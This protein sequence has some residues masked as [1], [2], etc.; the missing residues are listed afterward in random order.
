M[1][2]VEYLKAACNA[3]AWR[4]LVWRLSLFTVSRFPKDSI[5]KDYDLN[6]REGKVW[7]YLGDEW[8]TISGVTDDDGLFVPEEPLKLEKDDYP[9]LAQPI[10][11]TV[12]KYFYNW[13]VI[14]YPFGTKFPYQQSNDHPRKFSKGLAPL[15]KDPDPKLP[16][17]ITIDGT[18]MGRFVQACAELDSMSLGIVPT[19][20]LRSLETHPDMYKLR[21]A[22]LIKYKDRLDD[23]A[24]IV[25]IQDELDKLDAEWLA[26]DQSIDFFQGSKARMRRRKLFLVHGIEGSFREDGKFDFIPTSLIEGGDLTQLVAKFNSVREGSYDRGAE[27]AKGGEQ[28]RIIQSIYQN[29]KVVAGDCG[30]KVSQT[31]T[32][33]GF[34]KNTLVGFNYITDKGLVSL[35]QEIVN[36]LEGKTIKLRRP[37]LCKMDHVDT[38]AACSSQEKATQPRTVATDISG[39]ASNSMYAA[40]GA[41]HG[42]DTV[43][44]EFIP[45]FHIT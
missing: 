24:T 19:G 32:V 18:M 41:M 13:L 44:S 3:Q 30:T 39:G 7:Y 16:D 21:D 1:N 31:I 17:E 26:G 15:F 38:C 22:L 5:P 20:T 27:T 43:V 12:G 40:M 36:S 23:P 2:K 42:V 45:E 8:L 33:N 25:L 9:N 28:V 14:Y 6:Y 29:H 34:N 4:R 37:L 35:T 11:T 10:E